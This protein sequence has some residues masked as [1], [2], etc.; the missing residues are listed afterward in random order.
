[1]LFAKRYTYPHCNSYMK[2]KP[3]SYLSPGCRTFC[4]W[5][6]QDLC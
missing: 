6:V 4:R 1:M 2:L 3:W 5:D